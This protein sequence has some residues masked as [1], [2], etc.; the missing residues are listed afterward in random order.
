MKRPNHAPE[1]LPQRPPASEPTTVKLSGWFGLYAIRVVLRP[2]R[3]A[4][5][6]AKAIVSSRGRTELGGGA[7]VVFADCRAHGVPGC[8]RCRADARRAR[9]TL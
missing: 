6:A 9:R 1:P 4:A 8:G 2:S 7:I 3:F 5:L